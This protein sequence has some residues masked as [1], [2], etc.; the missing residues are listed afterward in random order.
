M[1][2]LFGKPFARALVFGPQGGGKRALIHALAGEEQVL[3]VPDRK[4]RLDLW[5]FD[6]QVKL[7]P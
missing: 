7:I 6:E 4:I 3:E 2:M 1:G 5:S